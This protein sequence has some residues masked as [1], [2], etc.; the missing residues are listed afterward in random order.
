MPDYDYD[1]ITIG[2][3]SGGVRGSRMAAKY[4]ARVAVAVERHVGQAPVRGD[5]GRLPFGEL[6]GRDVGRGTGVSVPRGVGLVDL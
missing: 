6:E 2:A 3:G 5:G 4:G 1:L